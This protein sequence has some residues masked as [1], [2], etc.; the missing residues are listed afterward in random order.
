MLTTD[1]LLRALRE[2]P[3]A[4]STTLCR[5]LKGISRATLARG[6]RLL[7]PR[8]VSRGA[9]RRTRYALRRALR[10][11]EA[12]LP[13][14]RIDENGRGHE[15]GH[16]DLTYPEGSALAFTEPFPWPFAGDM[17]DGWFDGLPY[18]LVDIRPQGFLGRNFA[19]THALD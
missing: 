11:S 16:L 15:V 17:R 3:R 2:N 8:V 12:S 10:G 13:L 5:L 1:A 4:G 18:P 19:H 6:L 7:G 14:Y 9:A